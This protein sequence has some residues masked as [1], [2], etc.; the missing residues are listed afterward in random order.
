MK[1]SE[2]SLTGRAQVEFLGDKSAFLKELDW[3]LNRVRK[4]NHRITVLLI[5]IQGSDPHTGHRPHSSHSKILEDLS[6]V[7]RDTDNI[8]KI[9]NDLFA[10]ILP[11]TH[12]AGG[13]AAA[14]RIKRLI[15]HSSDPDSGHDLA[16]QVYVGVASV[17]PDDPFLDPAVVLS[18]LEE[19]LA[20]DKEW[21]YELPESEPHSEMKE[22]VGH[23]VILA[24]YQVKWKELNKIVTDTGCKFYEAQGPDDAIDYLKDIDQAVLIVDATLPDD[25]LKS[26]CK[27]LHFYREL[28]DI[29]K[30]LLTAPNNLPCL[31]SFDHF[32]PVDL[33]VQV[34]ADS[35][36][37]GLETSRLR[38]LNRRAI[39]QK[40]I[41]ESIQ[42][43]CHKLNQPLQVI[44]GKA[45][46]I[47]LECQ[48][49]PRDLKTKKRLLE[50]LVE[51]KAQSSKAAEI[52]HK[53]Q[54]LLK[55]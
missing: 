28:D 52:N 39:R 37:V 45:E 42:K 51:I 30:I 18:A 24:P 23:V 47:L 12:E 2:K 38:R 5:Q 31:D 44:I 46:L 25:Q 6:Q 10:A 53:I 40:G 1:I 9:G 8:Y 17:G 15:L 22:E 32:L 21:G 34:L 48:G 27:K 41:F 13:E 29:F 36:S 43:A 3:N 14:L 35:I 55:D 4:F 20:M 33:D 11:S 16:K 19:D 49:N 7:L 54:R 50:D 26:V